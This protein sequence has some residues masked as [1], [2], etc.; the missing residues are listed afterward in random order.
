MIL[1][2]H[3]PTK[4]DIFGGVLR[5][6]A[7]SMYWEIHRERQYPLRSICTH[8]SRSEN[9]KAESRFERGFSRGAYDPFDV[10]ASM[11]HMMIDGEGNVVMRLGS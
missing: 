7:E 11:R 5:T 4:D 8:Y 3:Q 6:D 10:P 1:A 2:G 9:I